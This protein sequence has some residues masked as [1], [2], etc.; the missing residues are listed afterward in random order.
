M[1]SVQGCSKKVLEDKNG[2]Y[3]CS[4]CRTKNSTFTWGY[5]TSVKKSS[6]QSYTILLSNLF[7]CYHVATMLNI[8]N[9]NILA[10]I[11]QIKQTVCSVIC[12]VNCTMN[13]TLFVTLFSRSYSI[14]LQ[15]SRKQ[16]IEVRPQAT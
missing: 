8:S 14:F 16:S 15:I 2:Q 11:S 1:C 13:R 7:Y 9:I 5:M 10:V 4:K 3:Y 12:Y 6:F